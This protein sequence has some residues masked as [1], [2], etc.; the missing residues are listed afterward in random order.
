MGGSEPVPGTPVAVGRIP[1][2]RSPGPTSGQDEE[3]AALRRGD[4][5]AFLTLVRRLHPSMVRVASSYVPSREVGEEVAQDTW[6][7]VLEELDRFEGRSSLRTWIFRILTNQAK[8]RG[9]RERRTT[10]FSAL[11]VERESA[12]TT[13]SPDS[14]LEEGHRWA[15]HWA[16]P[17]LPWALPEEH[18]LSAE[19]GD[20]IRQAVDALPAAQRA[21]LVLRDGQSLSS[22]E[23][24]ELLGVSEGN[25]RVLL[26]RGRLRVR[27]AVQEY[28]ERV[29]VAT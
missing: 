29:A 22:A 19:L 28:A 7:A 25:Q 9:A 18:L 16:A 5:S 2:P 20:V 8:T 1:A 23:A 3:L 15:G 13:P 27:A 4:Q 6:V 11:A 14:F 10:P 26:H 24:C 21:V 17:V 12:R